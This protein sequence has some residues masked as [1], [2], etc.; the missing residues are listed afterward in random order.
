[1]EPDSVG[2]LQVI[3][4]L[5]ATHR[6]LSIIIDRLSNEGFA[7]SDEVKRLSNIRMSV[8]Q[9]ITDLTNYHKLGADL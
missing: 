2:I 1:M 5:K 9:H 4:H 6:A 7:T 3:G 8:A